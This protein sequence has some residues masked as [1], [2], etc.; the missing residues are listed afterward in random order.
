MRLVKGLEH[1]R[2]FYRERRRELGCLV[3]R[4]LS[5]DVI[6]L[7]QDLREGCGKVAVGL[8]SQVWQD[9]GQGHPLLQVSSHSNPLCC[10]QPGMQ[11][12]V[13]RFYHSCLDFLSGW[14]CRQG[15]PQVSE[16]CFLHV[17]VC[18]L[19]L[20]ALFLTRLRAWGING[21]HVLSAAGL[22]LVPIHMIHT[23]YAAFL[24]HEGRIFPA[25]KVG[26]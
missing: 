11:R 26:L 4:R 19:L 20:T 8:F 16:K 24:R 21:A 10:P 7:Y 15:T 2:H 6:A 1:Q 5:G 14:E 9:A 17:G 3:C 25:N 22:T 13:K 23:S 18:L 12:A